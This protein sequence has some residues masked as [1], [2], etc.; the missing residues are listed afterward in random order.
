L[1]T[2]AKELEGGR[3]KLE[4]ALGLFE[5]GVRLSKQGTQRLDDAERRLEILLE[6]DKTGPLKLE[7]PPEQGGGDD[8][9]PF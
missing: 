6:A 4:D 3:A 7:G 2:I 9:A 5:E 8:D 1:E